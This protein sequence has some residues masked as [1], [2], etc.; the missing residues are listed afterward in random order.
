MTILITGSSGFV[1][2]VLIQNLKNLGIDTIGLDWKP[3]KYTDIVHDISKSFKIDKNVDTI[4]HLAARLEHDRCTKKEYY[5]ANVQGTENVL[6]VAKKFNSY[7]IYI[8]ATAIYGDPNSPIKEE[9]KISPN[10][11]Y[12]L[13][14]WS[15]EKIC[16]KCQEQGLKTAIIRPTVILGRKRLGIYKIIF[17]NLINN[18]TIPILGKGDNKI[19]FINVDDLVDFIIHLHNEKIPKLVVNFGGIIP[20]NLN[21]MIQ[22][23]KK[24]TSSKSK[25]M[26][27]PVSLIGILKIL[28]RIKIIPVTPWQLSVMHKDYFFDNG[29]LHSTGFRYKHQPIDALKN[30]IDN[31]KIEN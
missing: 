19:S 22:E 1:G 9:T 8:S 16:N 7:F 31:Y 15:G 3:G 12:A 28:S 23:L 18:K 4:I 21:E 26:H 27:V 30:M 25:I 6:K 24:Y 2:E 5:S 13:T 10:G 17:K 20:G 14:K 11:N 29:V